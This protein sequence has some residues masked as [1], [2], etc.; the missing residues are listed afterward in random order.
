MEFEIP[1]DGSILESVFMRQQLTQALD[2]L[3][4]YTDLVAE[5]TYS[6]KQEVVDGSTDAKNKA[7]ESIRVARAMLYDGLLIGI[8][9]TWGKYDKKKFPG[10]DT[11]NCIIEYESS[12]NSDLDAFQRALRTKFL[13]TK[14]TRCSSLR[15]V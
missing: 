5:K 10:S 12:A 1:K 4:P 14:F 2:L 11:Y 13:R 7:I 9:N 15:R 8:A 6:W 3:V